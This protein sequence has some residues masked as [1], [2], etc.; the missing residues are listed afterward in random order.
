MIPVPAVTK[1]DIIWG[2][3]GHLPKMADI[4]DEFTHASNRY[5][6][7]VS[8]WFFDGINPED[9]LRLKPREGVE[10]TRAL[11]AIRAILGSFEPK[12][13]HKNAGCAYLLSEWFELT[14]ETK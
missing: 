9:V 4:P 2:S 5:V 14:S 6:S 12:H 13:E 10:K 3:I 8:R 7:F 11:S 1:L